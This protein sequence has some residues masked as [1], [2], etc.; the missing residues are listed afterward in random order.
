[1]PLNNGDRLSWQIRWGSALLLLVGLF[2]M[3]ADLIDSPPLRAAA[4]ATAASPTPRA[5]ST[6]RRAELFSAQVS[7]RWRDPD[8]QSV[9]IKLGPTRFSAVTGPARRRSLYTAVLRLG[10][11]LASTPRLRPMFEAISSATLCGDRPLLRELGID[12]AQVTNPISIRI[13]PKHQIP[14]GIPLDLELPCG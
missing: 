13:Q 3:G 7:L 6:V 11:L 5:F 14:E 1:M 4:T 9:A 10:P 2:G 8:G 12:P